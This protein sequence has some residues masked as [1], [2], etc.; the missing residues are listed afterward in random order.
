VDGPAQLTRLLFEGR[1][2]YRGNDY[3]RAERL[4]I[5]AVQAGGERY[6]DVHH[7]LGVI[8]HSWGQFSKAR[9]ELEEALRINPGYI[10]AG[11]NLAITYNDL[12]RYAEAQE[13]WERLQPGPDENVDAFSRG[14]IANLHAEVGDAYRSVGLHPEAAREYGMALGLCP[15][16]ADLRMKLAQALAD[17]GSLEEAALE[18]LEV[19]NQRPD[20]LPAYL[21][22]GLLLHRL[23]HPERAKVAL[24]EVLKREP[25]HERAKTYLHMLEPRGGSD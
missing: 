3:T 7:M 5:E 4:L 22:L 6:A 9:A 1:E 15:E 13:L 12:G 17:A 21:H 10:E 20:H 18:L 2:A 14:K 24:L 11:M 16:F 19:L 23:G 8:Y 25:N